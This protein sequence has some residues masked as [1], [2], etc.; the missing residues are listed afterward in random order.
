MDS[1]FLNDIHF[2]SRLFNFFEMA[3]K[4]KSIEIESRYGFFNDKRFNATIQPSSFYRA[5]Q[6]ISELGKRLEKANS[7]EIV[8]NHFKKITINGKE[9]YQEKKEKENLDIHNYN[10]RISKSKEIYLDPNKVIKSGSK[11]IRNKFRE[12]YQLECFKIDFTI[13]NFSQFECEIEYIGN[14]Y[15]SN[16]PSTQNA[17][18]AFKRINLLILQLLNNSEYV[19]SCNEKNSIIDNYCKLNSIKRFKFICNKPITLTNNNKDSIDSNFK[20]TEKLDGERAFLF[21]TNNKVYIIKSDKSV[22][23]WNTNSNKNTNSNENNSNKINSN[24][25]ANTNTLQKEYFKQYSNTLIDGELMGGVSNRTFYAFDLIFRCNNDYRNLIF[26]KRYTELQNILDLLKIPNTFAKQFVN[27]N[28]ISTLQKSNS[29][30]DGFIFV[31]NLLNYQSIQYKWK[32]VKDSTIDFYTIKHDTHWDLYLATSSNSKKGITSLAYDKPI[33]KC[34]FAG[35]T[36]LMKSGFINKSVIEYSYNKQLKQFEPL[37]TRWDKMYNKQPGNYYPFAK[38]IWETINDPVDLSTFDSNFSLVVFDK[39]SSQNRKSNLQN[40]HHTQSN[41]QSKNSHYSAQSKNRHNNAQSSNSQSRNNNR[42]NNKNRPESKVKRLRQFHNYVKGLFIKKLRGGSLLDLASGNGGDIHKCRNNGIQTMIGFDIN[43]EFVKES[44]RRANEYTNMD[45]SFHNMD[46]SKGNVY[47]YLQKNGYD[48]SFDNVLCNFAIH[49]FNGVSLDNLL[50]N[51][52][53]NLSNGGKFLVCCFDKKRVLELLNE[54]ESYLTDLYEIKKVN[55][56]QITVFIKDTL[57]FNEKEKEKGYLEYLVDKDHLKKQSEKFNLKLVSVYSFEELYKDYIK[58]NN[59]MSKV[60]KV[61]SFLNN[62]FI[63]EKTDY[64]LYEKSIGE[65][66]SNIPVDTIKEK[67]DQMKSILYSNTSNATL[68]NTTLSNTS[69]ESIK[70]TSNTESESKSDNTELNID[71]NN[72][73]SEQEVEYIWGNYELVDCGAEGDCQFRCI[74]NALDTTEIRNKLG[75]YIEKM[76]NYKEIEPFIEEKYA[77]NKEQFVSEI[78]K[79]T[80]YWGDQV[81]LTLL[82]KIYDINFIVYSVL[83]DDSYSLINE[84]KKNKY[85]LL[86]LSGPIEH[87]QLITLDTGKQVKKIFTR[88]SLKKLPFYSTLFNPVKVPLKETKEPIKESKTEKETNET[89]KEPTETE[90]ETKKE[91]TETKNETKT[92]IEKITKSYTLKR[93]QDLCN[94]HKLKKSGKKKELIERLLENDYKFE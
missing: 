36:K 17:I 78:R 62:Y 91:P 27:V 18:N 71:S 28:E 44:N 39:P 85:I 73:E 55:D 72:T 46:L 50:K 66:A 13:V 20:V 59:E 47:A 81:T 38:E 7:Q 61:L 24:N 31:N 52:S 60:E 90:T 87:Y 48:I 35:S 75:D 76:K 77:K 53:D 5:K 12:S 57:Y 14:K 86:H 42:H 30:S 80:G 45:Y 10:F 23:F 9:Y 64:S 3:N 83:T 33:V 54:N 41:S 74:E 82:S 94:E 4:D 2:N 6:R 93:L 65:H 34:D 8:F 84:S 89:E 26:E 92:D 40:R 29:L 43:P 88:A 70:N 21:I 32:S 67:L 68:S 58:E 79:E 49:Y 37:R 69:N 15:K 63:F 11:I 19:L 25:N 56:E 16:V 51:V 1:N 22:Y